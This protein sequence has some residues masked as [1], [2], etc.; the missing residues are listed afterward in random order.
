MLKYKTYIESEEWHERSRDFLKRYPLCEFCGIEKSN[1]VHHKTYESI[2]NETDKDLMGVCDLCHSHIHHRPVVLKTHANTQK[3]KYILNN[4]LNKKNKS[5][6][7]F[8]LN[9]ISRDFYN[10]R[11]ML[12][13]IMERYPKTPL[14]DQALLYILEED[15]EKFDEDLIEYANK[16]IYNYKIALG[17]K[18]NDMKEKNLTNKY[19][20]QNIDFYS[21]EME[22]ENMTDEQILEVKM[23]SHIKSYFNILKKEDERLYQDKKRNMSLDQKY[24]YEVWASGLNKKFYG[25]KHWNREG[26]EAGYVGHDKKWLF[27]IKQ[28]KE[29]GFLTELYLLTGGNGDILK[30]EQEK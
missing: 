22:I 13:V 23:I 2:G 28:L 1:Q 24:N 27:F 12:E 14:F 30:D 6:R 7:L 18:R 10:Y 25:N 21:A 3:A 20:N 19:T 4:L 29:D 17:R 9:D 26:M 15:S 16:T 11:M 8:V 5:L